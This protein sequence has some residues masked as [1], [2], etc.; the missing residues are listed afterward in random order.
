MNWVPAI[1]WCF[2]ATIVMTTIQASALELG[3]TRMDIS[4]ILGTMFSSH[5]DKA[6][7]YGFLFHLINGWLFGL[8]YIAAIELSG[9]K[10]WW[11]GMLIGVVHA[12][13]VMGVVSTVLPSFHPRMADDESGPDPTRQ[14]EPPGP[15]LL[16]YGKQTPL[17][18]YASHMIYGAIL[19]LFYH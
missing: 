15:F 13:F 2:I 8:V 1:F 10:T 3:F 4:L 16:N 17:V 11:F 7:W 18:A 5:R 19:G 12:T 9:L 14:L 6:K